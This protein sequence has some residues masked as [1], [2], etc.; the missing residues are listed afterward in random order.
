MVDLQQGQ[1]GWRVNVHAAARDQ[2]VDGGEGLVHQLV[3]RHEGGPD[4]EG[5]GLNAGHVEQVGDEAGQP[6]GLELNQLEQFGAVD[7]VEG[8]ALLAQARDR[9][10]DRRQRC[11]E[12]VGDGSHHGTA[13]AVDLLEEARPQGLVLQLGPLDRQSS[14]VGKRA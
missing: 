8:R 14:L 3:E 4:R 10:L 1:I 9:R 5:P 6:I 12:V 2:A 13:P 7:V 11:A